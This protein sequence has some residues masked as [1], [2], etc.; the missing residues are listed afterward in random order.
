MSTDAVIF[1][2]KI[3]KF[4]MVVGTGSSAEIKTESNEAG[5][6][7]STGGNIEK[8]DGPKSR[9]ELDSEFESFLHMLCSSLGCTTPFTVLSP[10][11]ILTS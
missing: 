4:S 3:P 2:S 6:K 5:R 11:Y 9:K 1:L 7:A 8:I 10:P